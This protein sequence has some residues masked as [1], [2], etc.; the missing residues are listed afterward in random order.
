MRGNNESVRHIKGDFQ[1]QAALAAG[2]F[3]LVLK[4]QLAIVLQHRQKLRHTALDR[5]C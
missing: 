1:R 4:I 2:D 3:A 5:L